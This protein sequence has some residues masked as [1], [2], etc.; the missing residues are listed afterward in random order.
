NAAPSE[1][2]DEVDATLDVMAGLVPAI[3][4]FFSEAPQSKTWMPGTRPGMTSSVQTMYWAAPSMCWNFRD[5]RPWRSLYRVGTLACARCSASR[6]LAD[7]RACRNLPGG[8]AS[9]YRRQLRP[10]H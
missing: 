4:V 5:V 2:S 6:R 1:P 8:A 9:F 7:K 3:H 10:D